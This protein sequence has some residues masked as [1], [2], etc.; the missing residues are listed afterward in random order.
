MSNI[1]YAASTGPD[2]AFS[3]MTLLRTNAGFPASAE[4]LSPKLSLAET[5]E[6]MTTRSPAKVDT[7][8]PPGPVFPQIALLTIVTDPS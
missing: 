7:P 2:I 5:V 1:E 3:T 4:V 6:P 8:P